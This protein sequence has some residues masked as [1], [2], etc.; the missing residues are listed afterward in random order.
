MGL[1]GADDRE[2]FII[3]RYGSCCLVVEGHMLTER[4]L[5]LLAARCIGRRN[6][7]ALQQ[8]GGR[9]LRVGSAVTLEALRGHVAGPHPIGTDLI[10]EKGGTRLP[11]FRA[12]HP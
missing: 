2:W 5:R 9:Y 3:F 10:G 1:C 11:G 4:H 12:P 6:D 7:Y 8:T